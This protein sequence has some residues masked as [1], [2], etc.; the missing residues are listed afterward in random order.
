MKKL[1][2]CAATCAAMMFLAF[3]CATEP[4]PQTTEHS[5]MVSSAGEASP[6]GDAL[7]DGAAALTG[8]VPPAVNC[9]HPPT[10]ALFCQC[11]KQECL[12]ERNSLEVC[13]EEYT[14]CFDEICLGECTGFGCP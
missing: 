2:T 7:T 6:A 12:A 1:L 11:D 3:G 4:V 9:D 14:E 8:G 5:A 13:A 10:C